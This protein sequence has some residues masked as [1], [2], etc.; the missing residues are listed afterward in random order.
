MRQRRLFGA[1]LAIALFATNARAASALAPLDAAV[2]ARLMAV[3][4]DPAPPR[5]IKDQHYFVSN[6]MFPERFKDALADL[7]GLFVGVGSEQNYFYAGW[8][9]PD[10]LLLVDFDQSIADLHGVYQAF[11]RAAD[12]ID[13]FIA[14]WG[15]HHEPTREA[16]Q[17]AAHGPEELARISQAFKEAR[18]FVHARLQQARSRY[19]SLQLATFVSDEAQYRYLAALVRADRVHAVRGDLAGMSTM[20]G[21][22][23]FA[24]SVAVPVRLLYLSNVEQYFDY[25]VGMGRNILAQPVDD[26]SLVLRTFF[27]H[28]DPPDQYRYYLQA[29]A[30]MQAWLGRAKVTSLVQMLQSASPVPKGKAWV[31]P[32]PK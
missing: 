22:A 17:S 28:E 15:G 23:E 21:V 26:K 8:G 1:V 10:L 14:L 2:R 19:R 7:G 25:S 11:F 5:I 24:R 32:A 3:P 31:I 30:D 29:T 13:S 4:A 9:K 18:P 20:A 16:L 6:E 12:D 27:K